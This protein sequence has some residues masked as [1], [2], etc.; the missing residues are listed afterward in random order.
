MGKLKNCKAIYRLGILI[1]N[2][3]KYLLEH[4]TCVKK[5]EHYKNLSAKYDYGRFCN[6]EL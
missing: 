4:L 5:E 2:I 1:K 3:F 6:S